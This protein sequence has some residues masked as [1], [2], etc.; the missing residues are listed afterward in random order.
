MTSD[1][2]ERRRLFPLKISS[3]AIVSQDRTLFVDNCEVR[4]ALKSVFP[5]RPVPVPHVDLASLHFA[6]LNL[7]VFRHDSVRYSAVLCDIGCLWCS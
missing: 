3:Y 1:N 4:G 5:P 6:T 7:E 2:R